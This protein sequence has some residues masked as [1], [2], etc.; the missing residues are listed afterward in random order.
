MIIVTGYMSLEEILSH[1]MAK[2]EYYKVLDAHCD[3]VLKSVASVRVV[4][5]AK[6]G[7]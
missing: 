6:E 2:V 1:S 5:L 7:E 3:D 4:R